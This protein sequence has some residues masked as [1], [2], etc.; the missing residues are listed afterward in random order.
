MLDAFQQSERLAELIERRHRY[1]TLMRDLGAQQSALIASGEMTQLLRVLAAKQRVMMELERVER[2]LDPYR[3]QSAEERQWRS[4]E[5]RDRCRLQIE[6][7]KSLLAEIV[8]QEKEGEGQLQ[9]RRDEAAER[10]AGAHFAHQAHSAYQSAPHSTV[11]QLDLAS[12]S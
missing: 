2:D 10:L 7:S 11:S 5:L 12:E 4:T 8:A 9:R 6:E 3:P 1:L